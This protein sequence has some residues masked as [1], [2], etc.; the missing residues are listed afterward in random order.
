MSSTYRFEFRPYHRPF[1]QP[2]RTHHGIWRVREGIIVQ[3]IDP[4]G[5]IG[6]GEIAPIA[7]FGTE[8]VEQALSFCRA[9][10]SEVAIDTIF[11]IPAPLPACQFGFES[12]WEM[13]AQWQAP[14]SR[15]GKPE[16]HPPIDSSKIP[17][18]HLLPAGAAALQAWRS[19]WERGKRTFK[20]KI[21]VA[22][23]H[24]EIGILERLMQELPGDVQLRLDANGG[25]NW[26][27][28]CLWLQWC[29]EFNANRADSGQFAHI[30]FL[31][32]PLPPNQ[33]DLMLQLSENY[34]TPIALDES[35][36]TL[37]HLHLSYQLG[38]RGIVVVKAAIAGSPRR[39][40]QLCQQYVLDIVW[41]S[42]FETAIARYYIEHCLIPSFP[43]TPRA[44][45]FGVQSWFADGLE[46]AD[47]KQL[48]QTL[49]AL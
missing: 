11:Q 3:L 20:W 43:P 40:R 47:F 12:A 2:L 45:G 14:I 49:P 8:S 5:R 23:I 19:H 29:D 26:E 18:S 6:W 37:D 16:A 10:P 30:E 34:Q 46:Q 22:P 32:Q 36:A 35:V 4:A 41:S 44:I 15:D 21:G 24:Q 28:A 13:M 9:L 1:R 25:L 31:E 38:W 33:F 48:W 7:A 42:A 27:Q 17:Y 39:L